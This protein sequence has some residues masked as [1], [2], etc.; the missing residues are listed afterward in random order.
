M[1]A[2][3]AAPR[4]EIAD[5]VRLLN[6][7]PHV[8][9]QNF[10][11]LFVSSAC[12]FEG[13]ETREIVEMFAAALHQAVHE[14][15]HAMSERIAGEVKGLDL[16]RRLAVARALRD[17]DFSYYGR[18]PWSGS[19]EVVSRLGRTLTCMEGVLRVVLDVLGEHARLHMALWR[20]RW[21]IKRRAC[22]R[23]DAP[24]TGARFAREHGRELAMLGGAGG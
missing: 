5:A 10:I 6:V 14:E 8:E 21:V 22:E 16:E 20:Y 13:F 2:K 18:W 12:S 23:L 19:P 3:I 24:L 11:V 15:D 17:R 7:T 9:R 1:V 4:S